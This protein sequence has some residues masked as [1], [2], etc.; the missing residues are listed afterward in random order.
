M[1]KSSKSWSEVWL[2]HVRPILPTPHLMQAAMTAQMEHFKELASTTAEHK[3]A[4]E[5]AAAKAE[6]AAVAH[7]EQL[8]AE[9]RALAEEAEKARLEK[10]HAR[11]EM[12]A[13]KDALEGKVSDLGTFTPRL[14]T[15][16]DDLLLLIA[17][18]PCVGPL[19]TTIHETCAS[20]HV[21]L[22]PPSQGCRQGYR[23]QHLQRR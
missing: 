11:A 16:S 5:E 4:V 14:P 18:C 3:S 19:N 9:K 7:R 20:L 22:K 21:H 6:A 10:E 2:T 17:S 12:Q 15:T 8:A 1:W 13:Q 23:T